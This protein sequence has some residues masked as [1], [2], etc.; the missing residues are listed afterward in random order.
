MNLPK[1]S[2]IYSFLEKNN[3]DSG[4]A[5]ALYHFTG[6]SGYL[7]Y[8]N[9]LTPAEHYNSSNQLLTSALPGISVGQTDNI[10][11]TSAGIG[12]NYGYFD[13]SG[14]VKIASPID[15]DG[16][17]VFMH[18]K[19]E[20]ASSPQSA[21]VRDRSRIL[22]STML[23]EDSNSGFNVGLNGA[24]RLYFEYPTGYT[25]VLKTLTLPKEVGTNILFSASMGVDSGVL[26]LSLHDIPNKKNYNKK[27]YGLVESVEGEGATIG[28]ELK[29]SK[30]WY[31]G[32][33]KTVK[34]DG[35]RHTGYSG[36]I[37]SFLL[38]SGCVSM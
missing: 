14:A 32:N 25:K 33:F 38:V 19:E 6:A 22:F 35:I 28:S 31:I 20:E 34:S 17:T 27:F 8:N 7:I 4:N 12:D 29:H 10:Q 15:Y 16:W 5:K 11:D 30:E 37:D 9:L 2:I 23:D 1:A 13:S 26:E 24:N 21:L 18:I 36:Y 3:I